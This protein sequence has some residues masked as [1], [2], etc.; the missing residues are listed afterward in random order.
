[1]KLYRYLICVFFIPL[2]LQSCASYKPPVFDSNTSQY[3]DYKHNLSINIIDGYVLLSSETKD[4]LRKGFFPTAPA[5][6]AIFYDKKRNIALGFF[7]SEEI[8]FLSKGEK[9]EVLEVMAKALKKEG[10]SCDECTVVDVI[11][12]KED[13][14]AEMGISNEFSDGKMIMKMLPY[15]VSKGSSSHRLFAFMSASNKVNDFN[16]AKKDFLK[17]YNTLQFTAFNEEERLMEK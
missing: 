12:T 1:M 11:T 4:K 2:L 3:K 14:T 16:E 17:M 13:V 6:I 10:R 8:G 5:D 15:P 9:L 7:S